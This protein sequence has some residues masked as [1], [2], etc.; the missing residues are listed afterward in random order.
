M[1]RIPTN[2]NASIYPVAQTQQRGEE[3]AYLQLLTQENRRPT[4][5]EDMINC[6]ERKGK[7]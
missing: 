3:G 2:Y 7:N 4:R 1:I 6:L 5:N